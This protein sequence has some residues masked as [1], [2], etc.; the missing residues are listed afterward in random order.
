MSAGINA[1]EMPVLIDIAVN[2]TDP[3]FRGY[4][5]K[6]KRIHPD[7]FD[8]M[9]KRA[10]EAGV[11]QMIITG[12]SYQQSVSAIK[13]C[14]QHPEYLRCTVGVHPAYCDEFEHWTSADP[15]TGAG[16]GI[17]ADTDLS[18][19]ERTHRANIQ[20]SEMVKL[21]EKNRD[22]V[23]GVGEMGLDYSEV[24]KCSKEIQRKYFLKMMEAFAPL[25]LPY[26][27]H[28]RD[29]GTDFVE[30]LEGFMK[31]HPDLKLR[32]VLHSFNGSM[33]EQQRVLN[34]GFSL[35]INGSAFRT[36][37][38]ALQVTSI[39][40]DRLMLE[41]DAPW[42]DMRKKD[43]GYQFISPVPPPNIRGK[44]FEMG[45][46][47]ERRSEPCHLLQ[48]AEAFLGCKEDPDLTLVALMT[49]VRKNSVDLFGWD[50]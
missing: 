20:L 44:I 22:M 31:E 19:E 48:V 27:F 23:I 25:D 15:S 3:V 47:L 10:V 21:I 9:M 36:K 13:L 12:T 7:D 43:Y 32:G 24:K 42:C 8:L 17:T 2:L 14:R 29:C 1:G 34:L 16:G 49:Q 11:K 39:P 50:M 4:D 40:L 30:L 18:E 37:E 35:S 33:E 5:Y 38:Q 28:S 41:T 45:K 46:C 26:V 6:G